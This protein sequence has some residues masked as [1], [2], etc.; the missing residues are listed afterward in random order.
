MATPTDANNDNI[1]PDGDPDIPDLD[2]LESVA[3]DM[4]EVRDFHPYYIQ[5]NNRLFHSHSMIAASVYPLPVDGGEQNVGKFRGIA[6]NGSSSREQRHDALHNCL[7]ILIREHYFGPL[8]QA[9]VP[10]RRKK[11]VDFGTGTGKWY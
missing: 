8:H 5:R 10:G 4:T 11:V 1:D 9:L 7:R 2:D 6:G 3:S